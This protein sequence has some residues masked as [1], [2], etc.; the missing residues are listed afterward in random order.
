MIKRISDD[1][2]ELEGDCQPDERAWVIVRQ[3]TEGDNM[4]RADRVAKRTVKWGDA[5]VEETRD[6]NMREQWAF[7]VYLCLV[8]A[9]NIT[10]YAGKSLFKFGDGGQGYRKLDMDF[11]DFMK[12]YGTLPSAVTLAIRRAVLETNPDWDYWFAAEEDQS[13]DG[14][15]EE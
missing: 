5:G 10:D 7:E 9:G 1:V 13:E 12:A 15:G 11:Q 8:D 2:A 6:D 3:A 4:R 14:E